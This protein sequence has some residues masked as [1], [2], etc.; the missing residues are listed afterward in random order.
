L[1]TEEINSRRVV[2]HTVYFQE[3]RLQKE[4]Y[5]YY[6]ETAA[7]MKKFW[8]GRIHGIQRGTGQVQTSVGDCRDNFVESECMYDALMGACS[9]HEH[10]HLMG[11]YSWEQEFCYKTKDL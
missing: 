9:S 2:E 6:K 11:A 1:V 3:G 10:T 7:E 5:R 8:R 4:G